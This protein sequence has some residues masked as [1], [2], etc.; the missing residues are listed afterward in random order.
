[1]K[2]TARQFETLAMEQLDMLYR[3]ARRLTRSP[4]QAEDLVQ[5]TY[6]RALRAR[7]RFQLES[8][9]IRPWLLRIMHNLH[10]SR[11]DREKR[12]PIAIEESHLELT[13]ALASSLP[14][15]GFEGMDEQVVHAFNELPGDYQ[16]V[17]LLW[18]IDEL[19]YKEIASALE[20]PIGTVMSRLHRA[21]RRLC[22]LLQA[23]AVRERLIR[24]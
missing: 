15:S 23:Y 9:G 12:Q 5:E 8:F 17:L 18:A 6:L 21:R 1:M 10:I 19:S 20:I 22:E 2:I 16:T 3:V 14:I 11:A 4:A 7:K 13:P 24:E